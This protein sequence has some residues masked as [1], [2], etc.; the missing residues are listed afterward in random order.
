MPDPVGD[1]VAYEVETF[2][3]MAREAGLTVVSF[4]SGAWCRSHY[5]HSHQNLFV[6]ER[7]V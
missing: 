4:L 7:P 2:E 1:P 6:L 3:A 5:V